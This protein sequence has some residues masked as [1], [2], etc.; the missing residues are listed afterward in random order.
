MEDEPEIAGGV[1][2]DEGAAVHDLGEAFEAG[3]ELDAIDA[4]GDGREGGQDAARVET[5]FEGGVTL[6]IEGFGMGH[7]A[8]HPEDDDGIGGS[9]E[10]ARLA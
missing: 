5:L 4:G 10:P 8:A 1:G 2:A 6:G 7:A 3:G 9:I